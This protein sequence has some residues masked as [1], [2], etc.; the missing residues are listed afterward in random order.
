[1]KVKGCA[2]LL[3]Y[4]LIG[5]IEVRGPEKEESPGIQAEVQSVHLNRLVIDRPLYFWDGN[6]VEEEEWA[7]IQSQ[8]LVAST[9]DHQVTFDDLEFKSQGILYTNGF[10]LIIRASRLISNAGIIA[11]FPEGQKASVGQ[12][13][14]SGGNLIFDLDEAHG[15]LNFVLRGEG[16]GDGKPGRKPDASLAGKDAYF[17]SGE[18]KT[19][20]DFGYIKQATPGLRGFSGGAGQQ[21]GDTGALELHIRS[22]D[23]F[24]FFP[25]RE[26]G[27]G[28]QGGVGGAG[29]LGGVNKAP[30][31]KAPAGPQGP[32]GENGERGHIQSICVFY[33]AD[34]SC[35]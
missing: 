1:M 16:G 5:C 21:G 8:K 24:K 27:L 35:I 12:V 14:R 25:T 20:W 9:M 23:G 30:F 17:V 33:K 3:C 19:K 6:F 15:D 18:R 11:T 32:K 2:L 4:G 26:P 13:G 34:I 22:Y 29:G 28:G 10:N 7:Q 31:P